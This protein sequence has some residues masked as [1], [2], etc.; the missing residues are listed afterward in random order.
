MRLLALVGAFTLIASVS[1]CHSTPGRAEATAAGGLQ[2]VEQQ[3]I[4]SATSRV[5]A[6][7]P[8]LQSLGDGEDPRTAVNRFYLILV[9]ADVSLCPADFRAQFRSVT[10]AIRE[11]SEVLRAA[12]IAD[13]HKLAKSWRQIVAAAPDA[14]GDVF[15]QRLSERYRSVM[16]E[17]GAL[18]TVA[19]KYGM[20]I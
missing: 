11:L 2:K 19:A 15:L 17:I 5:K 16:K 18:K 20:D 8:Q 10:D 1:G 3:A 6:A 14:G 12:P 7:L 13:K 4:E 9:N